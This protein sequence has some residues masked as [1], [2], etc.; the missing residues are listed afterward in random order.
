MSYESICEAQK[1]TFQRWQQAFSLWKEA[2]KNYFEPDAFCVN[3]QT[4]I[5]QIRTIS[6]IVQSN[7]DK[8]DSFDKWYIPWQDK[9]KND[10][11][12][13]WLKDSRNQ[14]E[15]QGDLEKH[16]NIQLEIIASYFDDGPK[17][18]VPSKELLFVSIK[19][20]VTAI[21]KT[22]IYKHFEE[23]G[24]L[25]VKRQWVANSFEDAELLSLLSY[26]LLFLLDMIN[27]LNPNQQLFQVSQYRNSLLQE[28]PS[29]ICISLRDGKVFSRP[30]LPTYTK[31][32]NVNERAVKTYYPQAD[33]MRALPQNSLRDY[34]VKYM[35]MAKYLLQI[36]KNLQSLVF[37]SNMDT[38]GHECDSHVYPMICPDRQAKYLFMR[39]IAQQVKIYRLNTI[40]VVTENWFTTRKDLDPIT[41]L[42]NFPEDREGIL[43]V[44]CNSRGEEYSCHQEFTHKESNIV[45]IGE[46]TLETGECGAYFIE[47][48]KEVWKNNFN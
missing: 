22:N 17:V 33:D 45:F 7:K 44:A 47:P 16:S 37:L 9:M 29:S 48:V 14:I 28:P 26:G 39:F 27:S 5:T 25:E 18:T 34:V 6:F 15:K 30:F 3:M 41:V 8:I 31:R 19:S 1:I 20:I 46:P 11:I 42:T 38:E 43:I 13:T 12:M 40:I 21:K 32:V 23:N 2:Q 24:I 35:Q 36:D 4:C 10:P